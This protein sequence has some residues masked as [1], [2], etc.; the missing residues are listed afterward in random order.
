MMIVC[1]ALVSS[2][3]ANYNKNNNDEQTEISIV[4]LCSSMFITIL[5][6]S[7]FSIKI[8]LNNYKKSIYSQDTEIKN[9]F[10][11]T[12]SI[13]LSFTLLIFLPGIAVAAEFPSSSFTGCF[14]TGGVLSLIITSLNTYLML[15]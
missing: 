6:F 15:K 10:L 14:I 3:I 9:K 1:I 12:N 7:F 2:N 11:I 13:I 4:F 8:L 5:I